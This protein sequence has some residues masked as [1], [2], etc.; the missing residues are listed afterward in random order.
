MASVRPFR[1]TNLPK[2][3]AEQIA[4]QQ[5]AAQFIST[6]PFHPKFV[7]ELGKVAETYL[8][9]PCQ[10]SAELQS[11][12]ERAHLGALI[13]SI[14]CLM[15]VGLGPSDHKMLVD[16]DPGL[17]SFVIDKL[18]GGSGDVGRLQRPL[19]DIEEGVLSFFILKMMGLVHEGWQSGH[20]LSLSLDRFASK[21]TDLFQLVDAER[22]Y[23]VV[24]VNISFGKR[25]G[26]ARLLLPY[27]FI[28]AN[29]ATPPAQ[30]GGTPEDFNYMRRVLPRIGPAQIFCRVEAANLDLDESDLGS[31]EIGDIVLLENP[32][33]SKTSLGLEGEVFLKIGSAQNGGVRAVLVNEGD[34]SRL[35]VEQIVIQEQPLEA[36]MSDEQEETSEDQ[37]NLPETEGLLRDV[38]AP[39]VVE[40]G[41]IKMNVSQV[42]R[43]RAG[44]VLRLPRGANDPVD[45]V[46]HGKLFARGELIEVDGELGVRLMQ[47]VG[48]D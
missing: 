41:R 8:K 32:K 37:D 17:A 11:P 43:L 10:F 14:S 23:H 36:E 42:A 48:A 31:L 34:Q 7:D 27:S 35:R 25:V 46:V 39:V 30:S 44:Q 6:K 29:F 19:T 28:T 15:V 47:I 38:A 4:V 12:V 9:V 13:P 33:I 16:F 1:F 40:L 5:S 20:E 21:L 45:L 24:G 2:F 26:Y 18:L 22:G 3:S